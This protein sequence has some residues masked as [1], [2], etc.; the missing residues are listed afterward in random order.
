MWRASRG[1]V[2]PDGGSAEEHCVKDLLECTER[3]LQKMD[4]NK[5]SATGSWGQLFRKVKEGSLPKL[6]L[7]E[8]HLK[9]IGDRNSYSKTDHDATFM[10]MKEDAM[11]NGK[12]K[13]EYNM[14]IAT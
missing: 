7:Y 4:E 13:S 9:I 5:V 3:I 14:Q 6:E 8:K 12:T 2:L 10:R 1:A 11:D